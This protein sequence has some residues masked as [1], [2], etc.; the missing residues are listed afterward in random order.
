MDPIGPPSGLPPEPDRKLHEER[1]KEAVAEPQ[2]NS[3]EVQEGELL[4]RQPGL[5]S[6]AGIGFMRQAPVLAE[7]SDELE[8]ERVA[9][10]AKDIVEAGSLVCSVLAEDEPD[11][12]QARS[13]SV[14]RFRCWE[15]SRLDNKVFCLI[16][17]QLAKGQIPDFWKLAE[18]RKI[19]AAV[20]LSNLDAGALFAG[21]PYIEV[22]DRHGIPVSPDYP[23]EIR[24]INNLLHYQFKG[25]ADYKDA[26]PEYFISFARYLLATGS[27]EK[28][29]VNCKAGLG[30]TG[31]FV[32]ILLM[33]EAAGNGELNRNNA[34]LWFVESIAHSREDR[35]FNQ[36]V[37]SPQQ[38]SML[39][40]C[41]IH[42]TEVDE[43]QLTSAVNQWAV[44]R[45]WLLESD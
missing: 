9:A 23:L 31:T 28:L 3:G 14:G 11:S 37:Q 12:M 2:T 10:R 25:W 42:L 16:H 43:K 45:G 4:D 5:L 7:D 32:L 36:L 29:M 26:S 35:G 39:L 41:L 22:H 33:A 1:N 24:K 6:G 19:K 38:F 20:D 18:V 21:I 13:V 17:P 44:E 27:A 40:R 8:P 30:R 15:I 34:F